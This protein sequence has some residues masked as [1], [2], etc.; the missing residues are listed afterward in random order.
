MTKFEQALLHAA[1]V[2][3]HIIWSTFLLT[4]FVYFANHAS[5]PAWFSTDFVRYGVPLATINVIWSGI[6]E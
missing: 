1:K 4:L 6:V 5:V 2:A 3:L